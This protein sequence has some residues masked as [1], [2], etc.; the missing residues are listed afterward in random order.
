MRGTTLEEKHQIIKT[1]FPS[2]THTPQPVMNGRGELGEC[3][4]AP[5]NRNFSAETSVS[6][7]TQVQK[8]PSPE[9]LGC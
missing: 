5:N 7:K 1:S 8:D 9:F 3:L 6:A 2:H 4:R